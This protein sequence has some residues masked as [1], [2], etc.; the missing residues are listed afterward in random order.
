[1]SMMTYEMEQSLPQPY[2]SL[3]EIWEVHL[4]HHQGK[5][6]FLSQNALGTSSDLKV[7]SGLVGYVNISGT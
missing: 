3:E 6:K 5:Q 7:I 4:M 2:L 1:M